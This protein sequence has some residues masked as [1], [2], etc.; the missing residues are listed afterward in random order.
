[1]FVAA[2]IFA[3]LLIAWVRLGQMMFTKAYDYDEVW[4]IKVPACIGWYAWLVVTI[5]IFVCTVAGVP[6]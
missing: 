5:A 2:C 6:L 4:W 3:I 1:M